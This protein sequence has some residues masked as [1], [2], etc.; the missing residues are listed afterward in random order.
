[1]ATPFSGVW[2]IAALA[3]LGVMNQLLPW[4]TSGP[5]SRQSHQDEGHSKVRYKASLKSLGNEGC[6]ALE[7]KVGAAKKH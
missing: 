6:Q 5:L 3:R 2:R 1:M 4:G 7:P